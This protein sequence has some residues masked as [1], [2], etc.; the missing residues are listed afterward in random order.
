MYGIYEML[1]ILKSFFFI[2][3]KTIGMKMKISLFQ[4]RLFNEKL[5]NENNSLKLKASFNNELK[6]CCKYLL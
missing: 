4:V 3:H 1:A 6:N 2:F 5:C